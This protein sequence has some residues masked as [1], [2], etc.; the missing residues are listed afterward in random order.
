MHEISFRHLDNSPQRIRSLGMGDTC[1]DGIRTVLSVALAAAF[2]F[3]FAVLSILGFKAVATEPSLARSMLIIDP[4]LV[5]MAVLQAAVNALVLTIITVVIAT[6]IHRQTNRLHVFL[7][8]GTGFYILWRRSGKRKAVRSW[9]GTKPQWEPSDLFIEAT[10]IKHLPAW[11][12]ERLQEHRVERSSLKAQSG[13]LLWTRGSNGALVTELE[14]YWSLM[15]SREGQFTTLFIQRSPECWRIVQTVRPRQ[16]LWT[17]H[18]IGCGT[19][20][21]SDQQRSVRRN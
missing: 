15:A 6:L 16:K 20:P 4:M 19:A 9:Q 21:Y 7:F 14:L 2:W 13:E 12:Q 17:G 10:P 5:A 18:S 3:F 1:L 8:F 11:Q